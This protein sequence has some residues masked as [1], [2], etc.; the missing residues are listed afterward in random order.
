M[1]TDWTRKTSLEER[2]VNEK[3]LQNSQET[4][5]ELRRL[6]RQPSIPMMPFI[7]E[8]P[9]GSVAQDLR[10]GASAD[11]NTVSQLEQVAKELDGFGDILK[12][13]QASLDSSPQHDVGFIDSD[14]REEE[15]A[16][17]IEMDVDLL[18]TMLQEIK[19]KS[20][21]ARYGSKREHNQHVV[22]RPPRE[23]TH[24]SGIS[25][26]SSSP[27]SRYD[28]LASTSLSSQMPLGV[29]IH[30][31]SVTAVTAES[32]QAPLQRQFSASSI[33]SPLLG[34]SPPTTVMASGTNTAATTPMFTSP[35][36]A[37][38][39]GT[40]PASILL[41]SAATEWAVFCNEAEVICEG[42][43]RPWSCKISQRRRTR[44]GG[45]SLRAERGN[46][47]LYHDLPTTTMPHTSHTGANSQAKNMV[48]FK[49]PPSHKLRKVTG[50]GESVESVERD[51]RYFFH[52]PADHKAFQELIYRCD[53]E[54]SWD[55]K[56]VES[57]R[58]TECYTQTLR[59][60]RET[61]TRIPVIVFYTNKRTRSAK[62][63]IQ[64]PSEPPFLLLHHCRIA[65]VVS[66]ETSFRV[67]VKA[68]E[69]KPT[70]RL[71]FSDER[72]GVNHERAGS[73]GSSGS[74]IRSN[75]SSRLPTE[76]VPP[77]KWIHIEFESL[78]DRDNFLS[79]WQG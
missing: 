43:Q 74:S 24:D 58:E 36:W 25:D 22:R 33:G 15:R 11:E 41:P 75:G 3:I 29:P 10:I 9:E 72:L 34:S 35:V 2:A 28:P 52:N 77:L 76:K 78:V 21:R 42:W 8:E 40:R 47:C 60:W 62:T 56:T 4:L 68:A 54:K 37:P 18:Q 73:V 71:K 48:T 49:E 59:L 20:E 57:D 27:Y 70:L 32:Y 38:P 51:P 16:E 23:D 45:L 17:P 53:L 69:K 67:E 50:Q 14:T 65:D 46:A 39:T 26:I 31:P 64:E 30:Q 44:D 19:I 7:T 79:L 13:E 55:I 6:R 66:Q 61:H 5:I 63:Y 1:C 12:K